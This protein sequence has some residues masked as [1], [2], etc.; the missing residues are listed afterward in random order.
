MSIAFGLI[1]PCRPHVLLQPEANAGWKRLRDS[2]EQARQDIESSG[3]ERLLLYS[4]QWPSVIGH[5]I[6]AD[7]EPQWSLVDQD[8]HA[9]GTIHYHL[10]IDA[11]FAELYRDCSE[12]RGLTARTVSYRGF[13]VDTGTL[14]ALKLLNPDNR[15]PA[16]VVSC[17]MY[18]DRSETIVLGKSARDAIEASG[19]STVVVAVTALSNRMWT[20][21]I[22]PSEDRIHSQKDEE[23]NSK[24]IGLL[25]QGRL[26]DVS[27]L[28][29][30]FSREAHGDQ[31]LKALW[32]LAAAMGEHNG[33]EGKLY[34]YEPVW[35][36]GQVLL[37]MH[38][39]V[40]DA[41]SLEYDED[42]TEQFHGDRSVLS[43]TLNS[44]K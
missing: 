38:P 3:A 10:K 11:D 13:P 27:Q 20:S 19:K 7:P 37:S 39:G 21:F 5:Q 33:Y 26:E 4:T 25:E 6:Q 16:G 29:R 24:L 40:A 43:S 30:Q 41:S 28:A 35:G 8:F 17:N 2:F 18:A 14:V 44:K 36:T 23:W 15:I 1:S 31:N 12:K 34:A 9:L 22:D 32:W 42:N